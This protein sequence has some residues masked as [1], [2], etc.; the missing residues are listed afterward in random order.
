[1]GVFYDLRSGCH[2]L[3]FELSFA[4]VGIRLTLFL[5]LFGFDRF[6]TLHSVEVSESARSTAEDHLFAILGR[7][8]WLVACELYPK[9]ISIFLFYSGIDIEDH[10]NINQNYIY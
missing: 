5:N 6:S 1:M 8:L 4:G 10:I 7:F 9:L 3:Y 2:A